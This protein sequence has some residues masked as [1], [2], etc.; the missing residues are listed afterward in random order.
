MLLS[1]PQPTTV[2]MRAV[3]W[4]VTAKTPLRMLTSVGEPRASQCRVSAHTVTGC[5][6]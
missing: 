1:L 4:L 5:N 6:C 2:L 3:A